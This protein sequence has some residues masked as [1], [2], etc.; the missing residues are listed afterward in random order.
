MIRLG[1][2]PKTFPPTIDLPAQMVNVLRGS[3]VA[4]PDFDVYGLLVLEGM[5]R[6]DADSTTE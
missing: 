4:A 1:T 2:T 3:Q 6:V 5:R